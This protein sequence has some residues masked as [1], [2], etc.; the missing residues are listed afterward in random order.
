MF[1]ILF[2]LMKELYVLLVQIQTMCDGLQQALFT[3]SEQHVN[4]TL[5]RRPVI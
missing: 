3:S 5:S 1:L 2:T 4:V